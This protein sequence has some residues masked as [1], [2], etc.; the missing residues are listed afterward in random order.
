MSFTPC[1]CC[2]FKTFTRQRCS[3]D[4]WWGS[5]TNLKKP[6]KLYEYFKFLLQFSRGLRGDLS[7]NALPDVAP[8][9][10]HNLQVSCRLLSFS[11]TLDFSFEWW[12][13][14]KVNKLWK[15]NYTEPAKKFSA[16]KFSAYKNDVFIKK[17][18]NKYK[19]MIFQKYHIEWMAEWWRP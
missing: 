5:E 16:L 3:Q 13:S 4:I 15:K 14:H 19:L 17:R 10:R 6:V 12:N 9:T 11:L 18:G 2:M 7:P 1:Y 8:A